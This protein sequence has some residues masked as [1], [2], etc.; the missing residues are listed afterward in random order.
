MWAVPNK[1]VF[2]KSLMLRSQV[3]FKDFGMVPVAPLITG[4]IFIC[5]FHVRCV[6]I[7]ISLYYYYYY[8]YYYYCIRG[9]G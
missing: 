3:F 9:P 6:S 2:Y 4:T 5:V 8:Y 1:A 7:L